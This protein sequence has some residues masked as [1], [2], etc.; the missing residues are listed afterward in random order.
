M[1]RKAGFVLF[2]RVFL[3]FSVSYCFLKKK[4]YFHKKDHKMIKKILPWFS[5]MVREIGDVQCIKNDILKDY[6]ELIDD[7]LA[8]KDVPINEANA[9]EFFVKTYY[10]IDRAIYDIGLKFNYFGYY[11]LLGGDEKIKKEI[12]N[13]YNDINTFVLNNY[14]YNYDIYEILKNVGEV[15][16]KQNILPD[17]VNLIEKTL[18]RYRRIGIHLSDEK[19]T[20]LKD[21]SILLDDLCL[22][23]ELNIQGTKNH[24]IVSHQDLDGLNS[25]QIKKLNQLDDGTYKIGVDSPT[26]VMIMGYCKNRE[27]RKKLY[28]EYN[29]RAYP[30]NIELLEKIRSLRFEIAEILGYKNYAELDIEDS[31]AHNVANVQKLIE[32]ISQASHQKAIDEKKMI[33]EFAKKD[34]FKDPNFVIEPYDVA[35]IYQVYESKYFNIDQELVSE[36]FSV[37]KT[38]SKLLAMYC[39][40]FDINME[41]IQYDD[42]SWRYDDSMQV[43]RVTEKNG[44]IIGDII[45]DLYPRAG[46][47]SHACKSTLIGA[48]YKD[49]N[50]NSLGNEKSILRNIPLCVIVANFNKPTLDRDGLLYFNQVNTFFHEFGH[51]LHSIFGATRYAAQ[52]GTN[53][54]ADFVE[55]PSQLFE[56]WLLEKNIISDLSEHYKTG[57]KISPELIDQILYSEFFGKGLFYQRQLKLTEISLN[58]FLDKNLSID[59]ILENVDKKFVSLAHAPMTVYFLASFGH[60]ASDLYGAKYYSYLWSLLYAI[61]FFYDIKEKNG[62]LDPRIGKLLREKVLSKG[63]SIDPL[64]LIQDFLGRSFDNKNFSLYLNRFTY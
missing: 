27:I 54:Y 22:Q 7:M 23:F 45:L 63:S 33:G 58:L 34:F 55:V 15:Y 21:K 2:F 10:K 43:I 35:Y 11:N 17:E 25:E 39:E 20:I 28:Y 41:F 18:E 37:N 29:T 57:E 31:M 12:Q 60:L 30:K 13:A 3:L 62:L 48:V 59:T 42:A 64:Y 51:A 56:Y 61:D 32:D 47:Y 36:Y 9:M 19:K 50:P 6:Q 38:I 8:F 49:R 16:L 5:H 24:I 53:V 44:D 4:D 40:F 1:H 26:Y 14:T 46:K 52:S